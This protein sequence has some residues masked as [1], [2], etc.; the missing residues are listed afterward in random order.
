MSP[1]TAPED[2]A[3]LSRADLVYKAKLAEQAERCVPRSNPP[4]APATGRAD[5]PG[6]PPSPRAARRLGNKRAGEIRARR[7]LVR[8]APPRRGSRTSRRG[9]RARA[10]ASRG[11]LRRSSRARERRS[12]QRAASRVFFRISPPCTAPRSPGRPRRGEGGGVAVHP[13]PRSRRRPTPRDG[14]TPPPSP[15]RARETRV[16][17]TQPP[18]RAFV[19][20]AP[21]HPSAANGLVALKT[22]TACA[23]AVSHFF[24]L[25]C[26][27]GGRFAR[28]RLSKAPPTP[29]ATPRRSTLT[30]PTLPLHHPFEPPTQKKGTTR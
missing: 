8:A 14:D 2:L 17:A 11:R 30:P 21:A 6:F 27:M 18:P 26:P 25:R 13:A 3:G 22:T 29:P 20:P 15:A 28:G 12:R 24:L 16:V 10:R 19:R 1:M 23:C 5:P 9:P 4:R 7:A